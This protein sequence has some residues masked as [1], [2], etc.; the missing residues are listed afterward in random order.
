MSIESTAIPLPSEVIMPLAGWKLVLDHGLGL[1]WVFMAGLFGA[2]GSLLG[3]LAEYFLARAGGRPLIERYGHF[4]LITRKDLV[5]ADH[6][7]ATRGEL[8]I[9]IARMIPGV[10][11]FISIPAGIARMNILKFSI[12][13]FLG[14][15]PWTF[16]LALG[17]YLLG[18][19]YDEIREVT[20]PFDIPIIIGALGLVSW[21]VWRRIKE[22]REERR[23]AV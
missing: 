14:A 9:F 11:G 1:P 21:F 2:V 5:R 22:I 4:F 10:R 15:F 8:T 6:W 17:G 19:N 3:S 7:F 23:G 18:E 20:K 12:Y 16:G 13:T